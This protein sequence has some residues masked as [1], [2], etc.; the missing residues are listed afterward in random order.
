MHRIPPYIQ[1]LINQTDPAEDYLVPMKQ[2]YVYYRF[3]RLIKAAGLPHISFH[4]LRHVYASVM[5]LLH[6]PDKYA[7]ERG[8]WK[9]D[10]VMKKVYT[11]T[12]SPERQK[13]DN[14]ID[15]YFEEQFG[16]ADSDMPAGYATWLHNIGRQDTPE[17]REKYSA[18]MKSI[19]T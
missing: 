2:P 17:L 19:Q 16:I 5:A 14:M 10:A 7:Q 13:V 4:D 9:T 6:V 12:F 11:H 3:T 1:E 18:F 15:T 8:G